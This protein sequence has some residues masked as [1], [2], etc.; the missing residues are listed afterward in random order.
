MD[1]TPFTVTLA[2][3]AVA[4]FCLLAYRHKVTEW[5]D[6]TLHISEGEQNIVTQQQVLA[7]KMARVDLISKILVITLV[8]GGL[9]LLI[10]Y[11][12]LRMPEW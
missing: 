4:Y 3:V 5:E 6:D 9:L 8:V 11:M 1:L 10:A 12:Y 7:R 2:L